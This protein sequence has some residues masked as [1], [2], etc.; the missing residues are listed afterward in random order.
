MWNWLRKK[1]I[2]D[3]EIELNL[4]LTTKDPNPDGWGTTFSY[5]IVDVKTRN[6]V[7][8]CDLRI[9]DSW[10]LYIGGNIG[11]TVY[12]PHRGHR[13]AAKATMLLFEEAKKHGMT[14]LIITCN[15]DNV[16][17]YRTCEIC[18]CTLKEIVDVPA[19]HELYR[20]GDR[21][22]CIFVK[23]LTDTPDRNA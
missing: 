11:Y 12:I 16:P 22:K 15:P 6:T 9:G 5:D 7:G 23:E 4:Y 21:Q 13:Y 1:K 20:Q 17:S 19:T 3:G 18:G 10:T 2:T 8:R 14:R